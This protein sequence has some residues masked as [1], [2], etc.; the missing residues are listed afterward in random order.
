M[1]KRALILINKTAGTGRAGNDTLAIATGLAQRGYE[2]IVYPIIPGSGLTSETIIGQYD[3]LVDLIVCSGGDGTLNHVVGAVMG[4]NNKPVISYIPAGSTNDFAKG[5]GIPSGNAAALS[6]ALDGEA[7]SYDIGKMNDRYFNYVAAFGAFSKVSYATDQELKNI[8]GYA[9]YVIS[10]I[11]ELP[12]SI[13][14]S[15]HMKIDA[16][17]EL[18]EDDYVFGAVCNCGSIGGMNIFGKTDVKLDDA[19]MELLLIHAPKNIIEFNEIL[20]ALATNIESSRFI[21]V[22]QVKKVSFCS[23]TECEWTVDGEFGGAAKQTNI[24]VLNR[25]ITIRVKK[26]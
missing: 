24:N 11:S 21:T 22:K 2:P 6:V 13:G 17:G 16:D 12:Q 18:F 23:E 1:G 15:T 19:E 10:A 8:L 9:A 5:L 26:K 4:M 7:F 3:G 25:A 20:G 14:N